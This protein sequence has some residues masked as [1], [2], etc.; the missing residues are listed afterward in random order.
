MPALRNARHEVF[1][2]AVAAGKTYS[3]SWEI[4]SGRRMGSA[5]TNATSASHAWKRPEIKARVAELLEARGKVLE[6]SYVTVIKRSG[7]TRASVLERINEI[8]DRCLERVPITDAHGRATGNYRWNAVGALRAL[9]LLGKQLGMF[10]DHKRLTIGGED[11]GAMTDDQLREH[12]RHLEREA[13]IRASA[14]PL[15]DAQVESESA[16]QPDRLREVV[17][18]DP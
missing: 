5:K 7:I 17:V 10:V 12:I 3:K 11:L 9:E 15:I 13:G 16:E 8:A 4:A 14:P 6:Q 2:Q 1:A 18:A